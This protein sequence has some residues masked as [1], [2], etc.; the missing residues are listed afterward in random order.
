MAWGAKER[1]EYYYANREKCLK[2]AKGYRERNREK[3]RA[4]NKNWRKNNPEKVRE[5]DRKYNDEKRI[6]KEYAEWNSTLRELG[7]ADLINA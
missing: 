7:Y 3:V 2:Q 1:K 5:Y 4:S 6:K